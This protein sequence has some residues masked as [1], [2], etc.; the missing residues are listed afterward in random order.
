M[1]NFLLITKDEAKD[2][3]IRL[4]YFGSFEKWMTDNNI[5]DN[6]T[7][8]NEIMTFIYKFQKELIKN[9]EY[10][11]SKNN[12][13]YEAIKRDK[14]TRGK[15]MD[16]LKASVCSHI[17]QEFEQRILEKVFIYCR[18]NGYI[19]DNNCILCYD[20]IMI[21]TI[22][23]KPE[24]LKELEDYIFNE[25]KFKMT[26]IKKEMEIAYTDEQLKECQ[27]IHEI[28]PQQVEKCINLTLDKLDNFD[29]TKAD[30]LHYFNIL[31][32]DRTKDK[33]DVFKLGALIFSLNLGYDLF[34]KLCHKKH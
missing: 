3:F 29:K 7:E 13:V 16:N 2:L 33:R 23:Y 15:K 9:C 8:I 34:Y 30:I 28:Q 32:I 31:N 18:D 21:E 25:L 20:G 1:I 19:K 5:I 24:L 17:L 26:F 27:I 12:D 6:F 10:L 14:G 11:I 4:L 22:Y